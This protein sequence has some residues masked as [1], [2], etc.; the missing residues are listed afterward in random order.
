MLCQAG[1]SV[2]P[3]DR[4]RSVASMLAWSARSS[5]ASARRVQVR[6]VVR[7]GGADRSRTRAI[8]NGSLRM[9]S[10]GMIGTRRMERCAE[11]EPWS[12]TVVESVTSSRSPMSVVRSCKSLEFDAPPRTILTMEA[13]QIAPT[14]FFRRF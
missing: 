8:P 12:P 4:R 3:W 10:G 7:M 6:I 14:A 2:P 1:A 13:S 5:L 11:R 9:A